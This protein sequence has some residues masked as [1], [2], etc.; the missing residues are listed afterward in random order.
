MQRL[1]CVLTIAYR[2]RVA[3][4]GDGGYSV[5]KVRTS[6]HTPGAWRPPFAC[7]RAAIGAVAAHHRLAQPTAHAAVTNGLPS[8]ST[9]PSRASVRLTSRAPRKRVFSS[10]MSEAYVVPVHVASTSAPMQSRK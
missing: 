2:G 8:P 9:S 3:A 5:S 6:A 10:T 7:W 4:R 1:A